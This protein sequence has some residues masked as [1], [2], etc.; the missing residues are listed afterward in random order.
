MSTKAFHPEHIGPLPGDVELSAFDAT[1]R[2]VEHVVFE[3]KQG[4]GRYFWQPKSLARGIYFLKV[5]PPARESVA[6]VLLMD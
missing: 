6:K 4:S 1:G 5:K 3:A 2:E